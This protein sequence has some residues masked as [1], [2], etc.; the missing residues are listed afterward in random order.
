MFEQW[1]N[2]IWYGRKRPPLWLIPFSWLFALLSSLRRW[3]YRIGFLGTVNFPVPV[4]VVGNITVGG[5]GKTPLTLAVVQAL[6]QQ[7]RKPGIVLRGYKGQGGATL[8]TPDSDPALVGDEAV[9]LAQRSGC[10]VMTNKDRTA[11][12]HQLLAK[13]DIDCIVSDDGLQHYR[14]G[15]DMEIA[16]VDAQRGMGNGYLLPAGPLREAAT[17]LVQVDMVVTNG[18]AEPTLL[19][20]IATRT[21]SMQLSGTALFNLGSGSSEALVAFRG[22]RVHA[23]AGI[24]NPWRFFTYLR[25]EGIDVVEHALPDHAIVA[26]KD[27]TFDDTLPIIMTEKD[28]VK[29][30]R[31]SLHGEQFWYLPVS[32]E[33]SAADFEVLGTALENVFNNKDVT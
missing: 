24:G 7:G 26:A 23:I 6:Q 33:F 29:I 30:R 17:R 10:P 5:T 16:V 25:S 9:L 18:S 28:A 31:Q 21:L 8:V 20:G 12:V 3:F 13:H 4:V 1:L 32:A 15:R 19:A 2:H 27:I 14:L 11:A 22:Q